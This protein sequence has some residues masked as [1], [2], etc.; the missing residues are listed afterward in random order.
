M[1]GSPTFWA[2]GSCGPSACP[3]MLEWPVCGAGSITQDWDQLSPLTALD[4]SGNHL[5]GSLAPSWADSW[6]NMSSVDF[7]GNEGIAGHLPA[8]GHNSR[9]PAGLGVIAPCASC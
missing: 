2:V 5:R 7:S 4:L 1:P 6:Q 8:G 9:G 3:L